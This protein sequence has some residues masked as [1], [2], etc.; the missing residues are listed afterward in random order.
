[1]RQAGWRG[2]EQQQQ[3]GGPKQPA[4]PAAQGLASVKQPARQGWVSGR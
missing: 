4:R 3:Q 1:M 2:Q